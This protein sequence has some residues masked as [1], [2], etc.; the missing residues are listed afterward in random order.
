[1]SNDKKRLQEVSASIE[2][3]VEH[4]MELYQ[5][6]SNLRLKIGESNVSV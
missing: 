1:M 6:R 4:L 5:E 3:V 2:R